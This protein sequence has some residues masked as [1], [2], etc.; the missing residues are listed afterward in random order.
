MP[1]DCLGR[2]AP[3]PVALLDIV[4][5]ECVV[6]SIIVFLPD[7]AENAG[8]LLK[9]VLFVFACKALQ[10]ADVERNGFR[11]NVDVIVTFVVSQDDLDRDV[12][13]CRIV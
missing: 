4:M 3:Y 8:F 13:K 2:Q 10:L 11:A 9:R 6:K 7:L 12:V 1:E 5:C